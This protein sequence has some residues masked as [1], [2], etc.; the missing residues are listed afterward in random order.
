MSLGEYDRER[1]YEVEVEERGFCCPFC[2]HFSYYIIYPITSPA[3]GPVMITC[4]CGET[5]WWARK[6]AKFFSDSTRKELS[7]DEHFA[8]F[9]KFPALQLKSP[10]Q[11]KVLESK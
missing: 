9:D 2:N 1:F 10:N 5:F 11:P 8:L 3:D 7:Q 6:Q 4:Q